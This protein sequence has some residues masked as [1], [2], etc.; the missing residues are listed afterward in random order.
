MNRVLIVTIGLVSRSG[1]E[2]VTLE[3]A[4]GLRGRGH[5]V[6]ILTPQ[7]GPLGHGLMRE[8]FV[9]VDDAGALPWTPTIIQAN[10]HPAADRCG[11]ALSRRAGGLDLS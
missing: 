4:R 3:T 11:R 7:I 5:E 8:G 1:T 10:Q 6:A 2:I 9:V